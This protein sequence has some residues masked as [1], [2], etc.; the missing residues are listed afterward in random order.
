M[1]LITRYLLKSPRII[2]EILRRKVWIIR[3]IIQGSMQVI[4]LKK[5]KKNNEKNGKMKIESNKMK[6]ACKSKRSY[7]LCQLLKRYFRTIIEELLMIK[8]KE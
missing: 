4:R 7:W 5:C 2:L 6:N 1:G 8:D 3:R